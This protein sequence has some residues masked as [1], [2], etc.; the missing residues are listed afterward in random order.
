M[1]VQAIMA[2]AA[3]LVI[4][5][6]FFGLSA[7]ATRVLAWTLG[8]SLLINL[9]LT[10]GEF[11][12]PHASQV[13][14]AAAHLITHGPYRNHYWGSVIFG[15]ALPLLIAAFAS[16]SPLALA[17]AGALSLVGLFVYEWAFVMAP[18][19]APNN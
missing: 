11:A 3:A 18:Q 19:A 12:V 8:L 6:L 14:S 1:F 5:G 10:L 13:A 7:D 17:I 16:V 4:T 9:L 15:L 2:G